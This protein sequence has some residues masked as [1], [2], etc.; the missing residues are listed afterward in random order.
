MD[1]L[2]TRFDERDC[3]CIVRG[4]GQWL[5]FCQTHGASHAKGLFAKY[6]GLD[7]GGSV[8]V[9][10]GQGHSAKTAGS[11]SRRNANHLAREESLGNLKARKR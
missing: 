8:K 2:T 7:K 10:R 9:R 3:G 6:P 1:D 4:D 5:R 11:E